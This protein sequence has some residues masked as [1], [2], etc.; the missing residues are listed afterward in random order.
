IKA[1]KSQKCKQRSDFLQMMFATK[2]K[3]HTDM[4]IRT[5][6]CAEIEKCVM[7]TEPRI[8]EVITGSIGVIDAKN[9]G[10]LAHAT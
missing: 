2:N 5:D 1:N 4:K 6:D 9:A 7:W 10:E 8:I 3:V